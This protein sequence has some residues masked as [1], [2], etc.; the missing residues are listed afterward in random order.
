M[1]I[2]DTKDRA[3]YTK[4]IIETSTGDRVELE[5]FKGFDVIRV[6]T[7]VS[8]KPNVVPRTGNELDIK[9]IQD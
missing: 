4:I 6:N 7:G 8:G 3:D 2:I 1:K 9:I 5:I